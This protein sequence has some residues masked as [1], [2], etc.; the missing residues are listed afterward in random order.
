MTAMF[1]QARRTALERSQAK[2]GMILRSKVVLICS[3]SSG[4]R[5]PHM[6]GPVWTKG[7]LFSVSFSFFYQYVIFSSV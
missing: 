1:E 3:G 2:L 4:L 7:F 5:Y 6:F